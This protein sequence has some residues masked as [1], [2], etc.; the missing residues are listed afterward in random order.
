VVVKTDRPAV[1]R[2]QREIKDLVAKLCARIDDYA[3]HRITPAS[4]EPELGE[5][6]TTEGREAAAGVLEV[7]AHARTL[8]RQ[9]QASIEANERRRD[10]LVLEAKQTTPQGTPLEGSGTKKDGPRDTAKDPSKD[11]ASKDKDKKAKKKASDYHR[12]VGDGAEKK[13]RLLDASAAAADI[14]R[15]HLASLLPLR[16]AV[17]AAIKRLT[18]PA[19]LAYLRDRFIE[20][21]D[22]DLARGI[23]AGLVAAADRQSI[24]LLARKL[25]TTGDPALKAAIHRS[26]TSLARVDLGDKP[27]PW[28]EWWAK[29]AK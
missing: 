6:S 19:A 23:L 27:G 16:D 3:T 18:D 28:A 2:T 5:L 10:A 22:A 29:Q 17:L 8:V 12:P 14:H 26:L 7:Y 4:L 1:K 15:R 21:S 24:P 11:D 25:G 9:T 13:Q 20:D